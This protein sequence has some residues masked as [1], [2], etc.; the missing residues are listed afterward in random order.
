MCVCQFVCVGVHTQSSM[1]VPVHMFPKCV[2]ICVCGILNKQLSISINRAHGMP[3]AQ[4]AQLQA[5]TLD[6]RAETG[7]YLPL[8]KQGC[9][10]GDAKCNVGRC[11]KVKHCWELLLRQRQNLVSCFSSWRVNAPGECG[12]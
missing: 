2:Y 6:V 7:A 12:G 11:V 10:R 4:V 9:G 3:E 1:P 8:F 5:D